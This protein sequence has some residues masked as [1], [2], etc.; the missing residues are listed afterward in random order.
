MLIF[1]IS[2]YPHTRTVFRVCRCGIPGRNPKAD[3]A[4]EQTAA[5]VHPRSQPPAQQ[6]A[7]SAPASGYTVP[8]RFFPGRSSGCICA[9]AQTGCGSAPGFPASGCALRPVQQIHPQAAR[10]SA[11]QNPQG[12]SA[13]VPAAMPGNVFKTLAGHQKRTVF[14]I[15]CKM[16]AA[17]RAADQCSQTGKPFPAGGKP[18]RNQNAFH[19]GKARPLTAPRSASG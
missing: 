7:H 8:R 11:Q 12:Q 16:Q 13:A 14:R 6:Q 15:F 4:A 17:A 5:I 1:R 3:P 18:C 9:A 2:A 19:T 10:N